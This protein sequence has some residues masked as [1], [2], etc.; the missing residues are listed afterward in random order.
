ME[1]INYKNKQ[2]S[3]NEVKECFNK[4]VIQTIEKLC[5]NEEKSLYQW[6]VID[7][8]KND[9][10]SNCARSSLDEVITFIENNN[11]NTHLH[12]SSSI[13][14]NTFHNTKKTDEIKYNK[15]IITNSSLTS[16]QLNLKG[17]YS[18]QKSS[19]PK[20]RI[21]YNAN[22][23]NQLRLNSLAM[24]TKKNDYEKIIKVRKKSALSLRKK[25]KKLNDSINKTEPKSN[26]YKDIKSKLFKDNKLDDIYLAKVKKEDSSK[27][28]KQHHMVAFIPATFHCLTETICYQKKKIEKSEIEEAREK[29]KELP[30]FKTVLK[31]EY[32]KKLDI[33]EKIFGLKINEIK[34][35]KL[36]ISPPKKADTYSLKTDIKYTKP[37]ESSDINKKKEITEF[38]LKENKITVKTDKKPRNYSQEHI[39]VDDK[40]I[41][42]R[43][44]HIKV[45]R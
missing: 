6:N 13:L 3:L 33:S 30:N 5:T 44:S 2:Y 39:R 7:I 17:K 35:E 11:A 26:R 45:L 25:P 19:M 27:E 12:E 34:E 40:K 24:S 20:N 8:L 42:K 14:N 23:N 31:H 18:N 22:P 41:I 28:K 29:E 32:V 16:S 38:T 36:D 37:N 43:M 21:E 10:F 4:S 1:E 15:R 9:F